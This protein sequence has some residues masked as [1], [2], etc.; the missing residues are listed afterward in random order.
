VCGAVSEC[1]D[2]TVKRLAVRE[3]PRSGKPDELMEKYGISAACIV[4]AV[5]QIL[6]A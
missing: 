6:C 5:N 3:V 1:R 4:K 2:I